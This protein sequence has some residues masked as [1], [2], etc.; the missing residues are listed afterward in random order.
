MLGLYLSFL[1]SVFLFTFCLCFIVFN[2]I[3]IVVIVVVGFS[4]STE[5]EI[6]TT[7]MDTQGR[8]QSKNTST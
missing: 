7:Y 2:N 4:C 8:R 5:M 3:F 6:N 1:K